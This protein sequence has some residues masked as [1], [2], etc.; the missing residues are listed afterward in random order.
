MFS[1]QRSWQIQK[2]SVQ[3]EQVKTKGKYWAAS[4]L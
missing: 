1:L 2:D 4:D 3:N